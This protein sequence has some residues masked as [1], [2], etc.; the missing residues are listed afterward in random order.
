[1]DRTLYNTFEK[2]ENQH[3]WFVGRRAIIE[4]SLKNIAASKKRILEAG[5]GTGGN[6]KMLAKYGDVE[7]FEMDEQAREVASRTSGIKIASGHLPESCPF[8][9]QRFDLIATFDVL[10]HI[11]NDSAAV[12]QLKNL[13][14]ESGRL[15]LTVPAMPSMWSYHD[16][17]NHHYRRYTKSSIRKLLESGGL[18]VEFAYYFNTLLWPLAFA[19]RKM[20]RSRQQ[21]ANDLKPPAW[22]LN[23]FLAI[24]FASER[25]LFRR[26]PF[27]FG[28]S[29]IAQAKIKA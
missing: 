26:V 19:V 28:L 27:P 1:M 18:E 23:R 4:S 8:Q 15:L 11:E 25:H 6:L 17:L 7:A 10:E 2:I 20:K 24:L 5:C 14:S 13:L 29:L 21:P 12:E 9:N 3:W 16:E 22:G